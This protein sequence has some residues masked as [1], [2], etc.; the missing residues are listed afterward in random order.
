M[1]RANKMTDYRN[2]EADPAAA[3]YADIMGC[4]EIKE[5]KEFEAANKLAYEKADALTEE[6]SAVMKGKIGDDELCEIEQ[7]IYAKAHSYFL[8]QIESGIDV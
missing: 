4:N 3:L 6:F 1:P 2:M 7:F 5:E 8:K